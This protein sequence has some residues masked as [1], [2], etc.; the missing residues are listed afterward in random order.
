MPGESLVSNA[1]SKMGLAD[2]CLSYRYKNLR[3]VIWRD[4]R[5]LFSPG[6]PDV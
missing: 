6:L 4:L 3:Q 2:M 5:G 1:Y